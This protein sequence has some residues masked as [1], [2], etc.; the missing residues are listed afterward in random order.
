VIGIY[1]RTDRVR[2][3][4]ERNL[5]IFTNLNRVTEYGADRVLLIIG[6]GHLAILRDFAV[7][8]PYFCLVDTEAYLSP[9]RPGQNRR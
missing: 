9:S 7:A 1:S 4:Y 2:N 6:S 8:A 3:W 5:R